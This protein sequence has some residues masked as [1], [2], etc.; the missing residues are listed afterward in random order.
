MK[1]GKHTLEE[2]KQWQ[3]LPL[4]VK[5]MMSCDRIRDWVREY[6][7]DG[8]AI[9]FSGGKDSTVL[10]DLVRNRC[11]Y[12]SV[13]AVFVDV[14]TQY[15]ELRDFAKTF[16][17]V[18]IL[19]PSINFMQ[20]CE[21]YGFPLISKEVSQKIYETRRI[22]RKNDKSTWNTYVTYR[23]C[24]GIGE[25]KDS[26]YNTKRYAYLLNADFNISHMCC[27]IM[28]KKPI[29]DYE[30]RTKRMQIVGT[31]ADESVQ[32]RTAWMI[33]GCNAFDIKHPRSSPMAFWTEN[34]VLQYIYEN[35]LPICSVYGEVV[36]KEKQMTFDEILSGEPRWEYETTGAKRTG[37][38]LCGFGCHLEKSPNRFERLK[39]THPKMYAML[40]IVKNNGV[41]MRQAIEWLNEHG[42]T[43]IKL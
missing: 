2:L 33:N 37:C 14:P 30:N 24:L 9:S 41:T 43:N 35:E 40:D 31:M 39:E 15:P 11:G 20:V 22:M 5:I 42:G 19:K 12:K 1:E 23:K 27:S 17:N 16:D 10:M 28:K 18:V 3:S 21:T 4:D 36:R 7:E 13:P 6:G 8:V 32:R 29:H 34:D 25:Y 26:D 38:M